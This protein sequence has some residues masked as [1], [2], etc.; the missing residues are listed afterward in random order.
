MWLFITRVR[1][2][3]MIHSNILCEVLFNEQAVKQVLNAAVDWCCWTVVSQS[4][5]PDVLLDFPSKYV[6]LSYVSHT[7]FSTVIEDVQY[8]WRY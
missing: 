4:P 8:A 5:R 6:S 3:I 7:L 2:G 1:L